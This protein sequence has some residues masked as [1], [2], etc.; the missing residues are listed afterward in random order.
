M[1]GLSYAVKVAV[2]TGQ[3]PAVSWW[4]SLGEVLT[5]AVREVGFESRGVFLK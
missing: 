5:R 4:T 1:L 3:G 2:T